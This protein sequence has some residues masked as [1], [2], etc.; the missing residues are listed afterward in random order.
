MMR[1]SGA[2]IL[3]AVLSSCGSTGNERI[4]N[5]TDTTLSREITKGASTKA[6]V[7]QILGD[8]SHVSFTDSGNE[9]WT[10]EHVIATDKAINYVPVVNWF[11][12]GQ[13]LDKKEVVVL[14]DKVGIVQNYTISVSQSEVRRGIG[15]Q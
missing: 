3:L 15:S 12:R 2:C 4:R 11:A 13:D 14:F 6:Q 7:R 10:Y 8:P 9:I 5:E 1:F